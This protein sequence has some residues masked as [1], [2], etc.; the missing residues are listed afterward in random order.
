[1]DGGEFGVIGDGVPPGAAAAVL[2]PFARPALRSNALRLVVV[3]A[4]L[5]RHR[6]E[7]PEL[8]AGLGVIRR[9]IAADRS[10]IRAAMADDHLAVE[11]PRRARDEPNIVLA[12]RHLRPERLAGLCVDRDQT[13]V[14]R[15][16]VDLAVPPGD[17]AAAPALPQL[18][19]RSLGRDRTSTRLNSSH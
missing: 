17:P 4:G 11:H 14:L 12:H 15:A 13:P 5:A 7:S 6:P 1:M 3:D 9:H 8:L 18:A 19:P 16:S 10:H 2:P